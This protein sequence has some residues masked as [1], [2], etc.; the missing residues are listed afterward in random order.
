MKFYY[1]SILLFITLAAPLTFAVR[2]G[3]SEKHYY[4][5]ILLILIN[6]VKMLTS[7]AYKKLLWIYFFLKFL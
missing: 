5:Q 3:T 4:L 2:V 1:L 6:V 7:K